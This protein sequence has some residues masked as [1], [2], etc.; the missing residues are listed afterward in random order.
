MTY[1]ALVLILSLYN[2]KKDHVPMTYYCYGDKK[3]SGRQTNEAATKLTLSMTKLDKIVLITSKQTL[4]DEKDGLGGQTT[5]G[6]F[7]NEIKNYCRANGF[8]EPEFK[9]I[10]NFTEQDGRRRNNTELFA[11]I[12]NELKDHNIYIDTTGGQRDDS[13]LIQLLVK[14]MEKFGRPPQYAWYSNAGDKTITDVKDSYFVMDLIDAMGTFNTTGIS[15]DLSALKERNV[16]KDKDIVAAVDSMEKFSKKIHL[17]N[18]SGIENTINSMNSRFDTLIDNKSTDGLG[19]VEYMFKFTVPKLKKNLFPDGKADICAL[20]DWCVRNN[21]LQQALTIAVERI[22]RYL[23]KDMGLVECIGDKA[24]LL[25]E[26]K[27]YEDEYYHLFY[28]KML[29]ATDIFR[30]EA[31]NKK[32]EFIQ[33]YLN[34]KL[35]NNRE[36]WKEFETLTYGLPKRNLDHKTIFNHLCVKGSSAFGKRIDVIKSLIGSGANTYEKLADAYANHKKKELADLLGYPELARKSEND[37]LNNKFLL[38]DS[39]VSC[40]QNDFEIAEGQLELFKKIAVGY[41]YIKAKRNQVN[42]SGDDTDMRN[43]QMILE[44]Y[45]YSAQPDSITDNIQK[46]TSLLRANP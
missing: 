25:E 9:K 37:S 29:T 23:F 10:N 24:A 8:D 28:T 27:T 18:I 4:E 38:V 14:Y 44:K 20:I 22:P 30:A 2:D 33:Q 39:M 34:G 15:S 32:K 46:F 45:G 12:M 5:Y 40:K 41:L 31:N 13:L 11:E 17:N 36:F 6:Y 1:N 21:M 26:K 7:T 3:F 42:H 43:I 16:F 19:Y 35:K